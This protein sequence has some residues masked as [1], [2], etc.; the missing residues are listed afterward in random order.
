MKNPETGVTFE[1]VETWKTMAKRVARSNKNLFLQD[2]EKAAFLQ[3][4]AN[5][6]LNIQICKI[7]Y[8]TFVDVKLLQWRP[9][10]GDEEVQRRKLQQQKQSCLRF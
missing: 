7:T 5:T 9:L 4:D 10:G 2:A 3:N 1:T 6:A 8:L